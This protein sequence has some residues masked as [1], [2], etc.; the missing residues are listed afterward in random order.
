[1]TGQAEEKRASRPRV[2]VAAV[3]G[4]EDGTRALDYAASEAR[5]R[6]LGLRLVHVRPETAMMS[7]MAPVIPEYT[8]HEFGVEVVTDA[9]DH[10]RSSGWTGPG[11]EVVLETGPRLPRLLR[12]L[13]DAACVV[14]GRR[15]SA[16]EHLLTGSTTSSLAAH[17][18]VP[19]L[20]VPTGWPTEGRHG[21]VGVGLKSFDLA[22]PILASAFDEARSR[23]A[24]VEVLHAWRPADPYDA[25]VYGRV[26]TGRWSASARD[27]LS[28]CV[29]REQPGGDVEW[30]VDAAYDLPAHALRQLSAR[31]DLL[32]VG[33]RGHARVSLRHLGPV[34]AALLRSSAC[35]VLVV[36]DESR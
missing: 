1:M 11:L 15:G 27:A 16:A 10:V 30:Y 5:H 17:A 14:V 7:P 32:V 18:P 21:L 35:P 25:A 26:E 31:A 33:R 8:L 12:H 3:D 4:S 2:V 24:R 6:G 9:E 20:C 29:H 19:V 22:G 36:P 28:D 13:D 23:Y 34:T